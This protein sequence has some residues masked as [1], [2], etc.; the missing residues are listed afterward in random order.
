MAR[1]RDRKMRLLFSSIAACLLA[2]ALLVAG[3]ASAKP[4]KPEHGPSGLSFY[5]PP[6]KLPKHHGDLIWW[7]KLKTDAALSKASEN[8]LLLYRS[9]SPDGKPIAVSGALS[10]P[11]GK[12]P[13]G[14]WPMITWAHGTSGIGDSCAP[15]LDKDGTSVHGLNAYIYPALNGFLKDG[16][17]VLRTDYEGL[18]TPGTHP[19]LIGKSAGRSVL[20]IVPA[21]KQLRK[22]LGRKVAIAGHSQGGHA[23]IWAAGLAPKWAPKTKVVGTVAFA[24]ASHLAEQ[25]PLVRQVPAPGG[26][27]GGIVSMVIRAGDEEYPSLNLSS[28]LTAQ[29]TALYPQTKTKCLSD[30]S[31]DN[32]FGG[33]NL[34]D[35]FKDDAD[36][37]GFIAKLTDNNPGRF[38]LAKPLLIEQGDN[39][40]TVFPNYTNDL[41]NEL[42]AKGSKSTLHTYPGV[43]HSSVVTG[44]PLADAEKFLKR[45]LK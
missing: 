41:Q 21:A 3:P 42:V 27:L 26:G 17:A 2:F 39:D 13:K 28:A 22:S 7:R 43:T 8:D 25:A 14:G 23:A 18:G 20:D 34:S 24:P 10:I 19:Y 37:S 6:K 31:E 44:D 30:L 16:Y 5:K 12:A 4:K 15:T 11:K 33:I 9:T 38:K 1:C 35:I 40:T 45:K 29:A 32:S 36:I